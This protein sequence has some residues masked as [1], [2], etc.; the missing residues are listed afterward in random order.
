MHY[1]VSTDHP[2]LH[3]FQ[4]KCNFISASQNTSL[5]L[6]NWTPGSYTI[7]DYSSHIHQFRASSQGKKLAV[8]Q[9][10]LHTWQIICNEGTQVEIEYIVYA[11]ENTVRTNFLDSEYAFINPP[12]F[13]M[14]RDGLLQ[15]RVSVTFSKKEFAYTYTSLPKEKQSNQFVAKNFDTLYD[16]PFHLSNRKSILFQ[17]QK[18][19]HEVLLEGEVPP[20]IQK[21]LIQDLKKITDYEAKMMQG[22]PNKY[23][24]FLL[25]LTEN[26]YGGLEHLSSSVNAFSPFQLHKK[27]KYKQLLALL[28]HEYFH[29]WNI[30]RIRPVELGPFDYTKANLTK[31]LWI[32]EGI[33]SFFDNFIMMKT[34][35]F[36][37]EE[38]LK[39]LYSDIERVEASP[40]Q[41]WMS[42]EE[43]SLTA[44]NKFYKVQPNSHNTGV[45]YYAKGAIFTICIDIRIRQATDSQKTFVDILLALYQKFY[46]EQDRGFSID[47]FWQCAED[48]IGIALRKEF[49][50]FLKQKK[51]IPI[52][53]YLKWI[54]V[55]REKVEEKLDLGFT[56]HESTGQLKVQKVFAHKNAG[57]AGINVGDEILALENHRVFKNNF[58][59]IV[60]LVS[61]YKPKFVNLLITRKGRIQELQLQVATKTKWKLV[62]QDSNDPVIGKLQEK[63]FAV[64]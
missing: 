29:L 57:K 8:K 17:S 35:L 9:E 30:K 21:Q 6:P 34:G 33:T 32:A 56:V 52:M 23:Y 10:N 64:G 24:L 48:S 1:T 16:S 59:E 12:G 39:E 19:K 14:Y 44:W 28:T 3:Y 4:V 61:E 26:A 49:S 55:N 2:E 45:S 60:D 18:C 40:G 41:T 20:K 58:T 25:N 37:G 50:P 15:E 27:E 11:F 53:N 22:N 36:S 54:G 63:F 38:Y 46:I 7:R 13:F 42:L 62:K 5:V 43:S 31:N 51:S 47:E